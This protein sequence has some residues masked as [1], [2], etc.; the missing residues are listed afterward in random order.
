VDRLTRTGIAALVAGALTAPAIAGAG[1]VPRDETG[2]EQ[3]GGA[4]FAHVASPALQGGS[5]REQAETASPLDPV[6]DEPR[7]ARTRGAVDVPGGASS[8]PAPD[9]RAAVGAHLA[10]GPPAA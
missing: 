7:S 1:T 8:D 5:W 9:G 2:D 4:P 10:R 6:R 3:A